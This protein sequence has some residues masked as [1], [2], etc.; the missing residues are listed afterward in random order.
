MVSK[1][2]LSSVPDPPFPYSFPVNSLLKWHGLKYSSTSSGELYEVL[3]DTAD[4]I[5]SNTIP[6]RHTHQM[7]LDPDLKSGHLKN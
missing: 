2:C 6:D 5:H 4:P 3:S 7:F 1:W